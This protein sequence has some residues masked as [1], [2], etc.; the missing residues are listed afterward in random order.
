MENAKT[1]ID[2]LGGPAKLAQKLG[3]SDRPGQIQRIS[4]WKKR[5][6][7][8]RVMLALA[9]VFGIG[10]AAPRRPRRRTQMR[11]PEKRE[12]IPIGPIDI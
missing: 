2:R 7:P 12:P 3:L 10:S 5:G 8:A 9:D 1:L 4:N 11:D 6:I